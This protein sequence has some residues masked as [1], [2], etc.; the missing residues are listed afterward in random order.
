LNRQDCSHEPET[1]LPG[2]PPAAVLEPSPG[3][4]L[5]WRQV[6]AGLAAPGFERD[7]RSLVR[8]LAESGLAA[9]VLVLALPVMLAVGIAVRFDSPGPA[10]FRQWRVGRGGRLFR[11]TKF[12]TLYHD[13][14]ERFPHLY[15]YRYTAG[16]I[17]QLFF[18]VPNDPRVTRIGE[19]LRRTT[20]DELPNFWHVFTGDMA[21]VGPRPEIPE[22]LPYYSDKHLMKFAVPPGLTGLAQISGRGRLRFLETAELDAEYVR[23]RSLRLD[24]RILARTISLIL[25]QDGAF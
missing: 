11:F 8:R 2:G 22:M 19:W 14:S 10:L 25:R 13:A 23:N 18:K 9:M 4:R 21:L 1:R 3:D 7:D 5:H 20:L 24:A 12:R 16:E 6:A 15:A 17:E